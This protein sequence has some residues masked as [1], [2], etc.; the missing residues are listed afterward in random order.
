MRTPMSGRPA[1]FAT[2]ASLRLV[3]AVVHSDLDTAIC[4]S[5][6]RTQE[7]AGVEVG[8][9]A[10]DACFESRNQAAGAGGIANDNDFAVRCLPQVACVDGWRPGKI[11][12][13]C[14][15]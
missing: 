13:V 4:D 8:V 2:P 14:A 1:G 11:L 3:H 10:V 9:G 5:G 7:F 15:A 6:I 12:I